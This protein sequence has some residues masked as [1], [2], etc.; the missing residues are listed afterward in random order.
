LT[1]NTIR[2]LTCVALAAVAACDGEAGANGVAGPAGD[3]AGA[4]AATSFTL[5]QGGPEEDLLAQGSS[6]TLT[7][8]ADG[9]TTGHMFVPAALTGESDFDE[10]LDGTWTQA[11]DVVRLEHT[12]DTFLRDIDLVVSGN[13]LTGQ[14]SDP[15]FVLAIVFT[16]N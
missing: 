14:V 13:E 2:R 1:T 10:D 7:L 8:L 15:T 3:A 11:D 12:A 4:Y 5:N 9:T 16:R 6:I